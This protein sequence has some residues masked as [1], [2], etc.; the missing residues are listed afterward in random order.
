MPEA[1]EKSYSPALVATLRALLNRE[2]AQ[3]P[4][5]EELS[6]CGPKGA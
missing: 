2:P 3:R 5:A 6:M 1:A 4:S